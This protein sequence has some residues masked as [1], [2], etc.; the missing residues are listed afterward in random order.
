ML[1]TDCSDIAARK[2]QPVALSFTC[3]RVGSRV[4][5][6]S[7]IVRR[8]IEREKWQGHPFKFLSPRSYTDMFV[9]TVKLTC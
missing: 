1:Q 7:H 4:G 9:Y 3:N 5:V 6:I 8:I 2:D